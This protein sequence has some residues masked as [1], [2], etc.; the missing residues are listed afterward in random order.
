MGTNLLTGAVVGA[1][2]GMIL[3]VPTALMLLATAFMDPRT[4]P[5]AL[6]AVAALGIPAACGLVFYRRYDF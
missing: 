6:W 1:L 3:S 2:L 5:S 4:R